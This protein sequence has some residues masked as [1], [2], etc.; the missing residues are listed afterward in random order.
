[1]TQPRRWQPQ[2]RRQ[3]IVC[4]TTPAYIFIRTPE[5]ERALEETELVLGERDEHILGLTG[6]GHIGQLSLTRGAWLGLTKATHARQGAIPHLAVVVERHLV[7]LAP[8]ARLLVPAEG[9]VRRV[10]VV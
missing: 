1:M 4:A 8:E 10:G 2:P 9:R 3:A 6:K 5:R 7:I